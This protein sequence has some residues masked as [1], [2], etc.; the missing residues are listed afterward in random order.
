M[1]TILPSFSV[2]RSASCCSKGAP[3]SLAASGLP[4]QH[5]HPLSSP[6]SMIRSA[7]FANVQEAVKILAGRGRHR[8]ETPPTPPP[9]LGF[10]VPIREY[11]TSGSKKPGSQKVPAPPSARTA[12]RTISTFSCDIA[13]SERPTASRASRP[14]VEVGPTRIT[15]R[16]ASEPPAGTRSIGVSLPALVGT[17][18]PGCERQVP[19]PRGTRPPLKSGK[20][21]SKS[22]HQRR[23]PSWP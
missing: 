10:S 18:P 4:A 21:L 15:S 22:V 2:N 1:P 8:L 7:S 9:S 5:E 13:Y 16:A 3:L 19:R 6:R 17:S 12:A 11:T 14:C 20:E 23:V